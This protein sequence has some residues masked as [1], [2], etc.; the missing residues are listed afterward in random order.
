MLGTNDVSRATF[1]PWVSCGGRTAW[2]QRVSKA[3]DVGGGGGVYLVLH[4]DLGGQR[5]VRV[6][7][8]AEAQ[9][10]LLHLVLGLQAPRRL[11][12]V[13]VAGAGRVELLQPTHALEAGMRPG[14]RGWEEQRTRWNVLL[15]SKRKRLKG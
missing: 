3:S 12:R 15:T 11:P 5:V 7:L 2:R 1:R 13:R 8:L 10:Q 9:A 4:G 6:P 14:G